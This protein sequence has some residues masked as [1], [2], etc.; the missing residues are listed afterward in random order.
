MKQL[1]ACPV[2]VKKHVEIV[3]NVRHK[4]EV[5]DSNEIQ[6]EPFEGWYDEAPAADQNEDNLFIED[7]YSEDYRGKSQIEVEVKNTDHFKQYTFDTDYLITLKSARMSKEAATPFVV[8]KTGDKK[9]KATELDTIYRT[10]K[11]IKYSEYKQGIRFGFIRVSDSFRYAKYNLEK[12]Q[13][14]VGVVNDEIPIRKK[15]GFNQKRVGYIKLSEGTSTEDYYVEATKSRGILWM[16]LMTLVIAALVILLCGYDWGGWH[17][18]WDGL[19]A[20]KTSITDVQEQNQLSIN[21][22][23]DVELNEDGFINLGLTSDGEDDL[24]F[25]V[26]I[27]C[28]AIEEDNLIY[29]SDKLMTGAGLEKIEPH[30]LGDLKA[31]NY[32]CIVLCEVFKD[33]GSFIGTLESHFILK[34]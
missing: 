1:F 33:S 11:K 21:H 34:V 12:T 24:Q 31:G 32:T 16:I 19:T 8:L 5:K 6:V 25:K 23:A 14:L 9:S 7:F 29:E 30:G 26:R 13:Q 20:Y 10:D 3:D 22:E 18:N 17:F 28:G 2:K 27:Y 4:I 15:K